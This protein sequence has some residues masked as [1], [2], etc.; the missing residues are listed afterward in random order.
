MKQLAFTIV[1]MCAGR[2]VAADKLKSDVKILNRQDNET[3]YTYVVPGYS[4]LNSNTNVGCVGVA[5]SVNCNGSTNATSL[6]MPAQQISYR[7]RGATF[8]LRL[9]DGRMA[10]VNCESKFAERFAGQRG[11]RRSCRMPLVDDIQAEFDGDKAKLKWSVSLDG[12]KVESET[13]KILAVFPKP[14]P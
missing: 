7:V 5:N 11:N 8:T 9:P 6:S 1:L 4:T 2:A 12:K 14:Q 10:V 3:D 13:Y